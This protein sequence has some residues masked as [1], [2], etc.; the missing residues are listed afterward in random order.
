MMMTVYG[1]VVFVLVAYLIL[2][3]Y[4]RSHASEG[5]VTITEGDTSVLSA[6]NNPPSKSPNNSVTSSSADTQMTAPS[7]SQS[8]STVEAATDA[9]T[10]DSRPAVPPDGKAYSGSG[11][12]ELYREG[13][14]TYQ[15]N[16]DT[17]ASCVMYASLREWR[18]PLVYRHSCR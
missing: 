4:Q 6:S 14:I 5:T 13:N 18:N 16:T 17:G 7:S 9:P 11:H 15:Y 12:L 8:L 3:M 10:A 1:L 2:V